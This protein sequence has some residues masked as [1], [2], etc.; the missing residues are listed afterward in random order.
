MSQYIG[1]FH[2]LAHVKGFAGSNFIAL[3]CNR[4]SAIICSIELMELKIY[5]NTQFVILTDG[6][7]TKNLEDTIECKNKTEVLLAISKIEA[8]EVNS[9]I[10]FNEN[11]N[12]LF[13]WFESEFRYIEAAGGLVVNERDEYL[14]IYRNNIWDLAKGKLDSGETPK[15]AAVREVQE[16]TG[17]QQISL[18]NYMCSTWHTYP[19]KKGKVLKQTYWYAMQSN[20]SERLIPQIEEGITELRWIAKKDFKEVLNNTYPSVVDVLEQ[21][22]F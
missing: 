20:S 14:F 22:K 16:E 6:K 15:I 13:S 8:G 11:Y 19:H 4:F 3:I 1:D 10:L 9:V 17:L 2:P 7:N 18:G 21:T 12:E 5:F